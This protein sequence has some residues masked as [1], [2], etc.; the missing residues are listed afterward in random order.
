MVTCGEPPLVEVT[1]AT[2][3]GTHITCSSSLG[4]RS[5]RTLRLEEPWRGGEEKGGEEEEE[6]R[7]GG[8]ERRR[9]ERRE[10]K[11]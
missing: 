4:G 2:E 7:G 6:R 3:T 5:Q 9:E 10:K 8:E 11:R 1:H